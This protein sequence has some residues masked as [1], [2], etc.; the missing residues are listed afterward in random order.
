MMMIAPNFVDLQKEGVA[1]EEEAGD[2]R[3][4]CQTEALTSSTDA[5]T[6]LSRSRML[7]AMNKKKYGRRYG[8]QINRKGRGG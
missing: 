8:V 4:E 7:D 2:Q 6:G 1:G 3:K 5:F